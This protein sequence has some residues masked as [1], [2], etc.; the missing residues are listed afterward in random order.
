M[1]KFVTLLLV[2]FPLLLSAQPADREAVL[3]LQK[4]N[5]FFRL[6]MTSYVD[7]M[8]YEKVVE[9]GIKNMLLE[10]DPHS[11]Y[12]SPEEM[13]EMMG[14]FEGSF[15]GVG[16][17]YDLL[18]DTLIVVNTIGGGPADQAGV[19]PND[20][21]VAVDDQPIVGMNRVEIADR[22]RG[23]TGTDVRLQI[24]RRGESQP[25]EFLVTRGEIPITT[26]DLAYRVS[27]RIGYVII[28][29][30]ARNTVEEFLQA[31]DSMSGI[32]GVILDLRDN[33]GGLFESAI[34]L[35]ECFLRKGDRITYT[36]GKRVSPVLYTAQRDGVLADK[37]LVLMINE[38]SASAS[39]LVAGAIQDWDRG[40]LV[41]RTTF[42]KGLVQRL[43]P[44]PDGSAIRLTMARYHT[45]VGRVIQRPFKQ[46]GK[47]EYYT[48]Y[49]N[50]L[51][52]GTDSIPAD[53]PVY[54]T[55]RSGREVFGGGSIRPDIELA[56]DTLDYDFWAK[57][58]RVGALRQYTVSYL[59]QHR[60]ELEERY[61]DF[62]SF[63]RD[64]V[65]D[66]AMLQEFIS[67]V[68]ESYDVTLEPEV[69]ERSKEELGLV[70]KSI[71]AQKI[72]SDW[73]YYR[74]VAETMDRE[75]HQAVAIM[76]RWLDSPEEVVTDSLIHRIS[77]SVR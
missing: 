16:V 62:E 57:I 17:E 35:S 15:A 19:L 28:N 74:I 38:S 20:R 9:S 34:E 3:Q 58:I 23:E 45:P 48:A 66:E 37:K 6:L 4:L 32:E 2:L 72:W 69:V 41:G 76:E 46:G 44:L 71:I 14:D 51:E 5:R 68:Q 56:P 29:R 22:L 7:T 60:K 47:D 64:F 26:I 24:V 13:E 49:I 1:K 21:I 63:K 18:N 65:C 52:E 50:R 30:F 42:G 27:D 40:I 67:F 11:T 43:F 36:E 12:A 73:A 10:L 77:E 25:L 31:I 39:E 33:G 70:L 54:Q 59:D 75:F 53:A 8:D 55:L 61:P